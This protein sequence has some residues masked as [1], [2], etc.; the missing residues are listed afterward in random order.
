MDTNAFLQGRQYGDRKGGG[1][2]SQRLNRRE[3]ALTII[4][5]NPFVQRVCL[6]FHS[7]IMTGRPPLFL[8][9]STHL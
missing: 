1:H 5:N 8:L 9:F 3:Q 7:L 2:Q 6:C 4:E